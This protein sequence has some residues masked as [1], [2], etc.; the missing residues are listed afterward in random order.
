MKNH[1]DG[2][3]SNYRDADDSDMYDGSVGADDEDE[4]DDENHKCL[5]SEYRPESA[6]L[7]EHA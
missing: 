2:D 7:A 4:E 6:L 5:G 3:E 1:S